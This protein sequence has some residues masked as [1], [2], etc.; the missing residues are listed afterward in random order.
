MRAGLLLS[1]KGKAA[2]GVT[3]PL[4]TQDALPPKESGVQPG[5][6]FWFLF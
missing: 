4:L 3:P 6:P 1:C 5:A 2:A